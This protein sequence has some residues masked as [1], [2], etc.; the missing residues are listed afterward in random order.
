MARIRH[1]ALLTKDTEKLATF[2][3]TS[4]G[5]NEVARSGEPERKRPGD[6]PVGR[7][8][9]SGHS[10]GAQSTGRHIPFWDGSRRIQG[11]AQTAKSTGATGER[12]ICLATAVLPRPLSWI[13]WVRASICRGGGRFSLDRS[14]R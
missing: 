14:C 9:Q 11:A 4:F 7:P 3:K 5:L 8:Y 2:Y 12:P 1:I 13:R 10:S 6:L